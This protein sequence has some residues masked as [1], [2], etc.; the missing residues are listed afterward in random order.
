MIPLKCP[1]CKEEDLQSIAFLCSDEDHIPKYKE[2]KC[3]SCLLKF[4]VSLETDKIVDKIQI[5]EF[6]E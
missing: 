1:R 4:L 5:K 6:L 3:Q 2:V